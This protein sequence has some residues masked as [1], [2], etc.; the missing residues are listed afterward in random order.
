M[1]NNDCT[2]NTDENN[3]DET[4]IY[5]CLLEAGYRDIKPENEENSNNN[6]FETRPASSML[7][8]TTTTSSSLSELDGD[9][10]SQIRKTTKTKTKN[11]S[12]HFMIQK[13]FVAELATLGILIHPMKHQRMLEAI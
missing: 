5:D 6:G 11:A 1:N 10:S 4:Q 2:L 8:L 12:S 3:E 13:V 9:T 7:S